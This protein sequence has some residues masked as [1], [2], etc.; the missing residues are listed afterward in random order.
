MMDL[1]QISLRVKIAVIH[2]NLILTVLVVMMMKKLRW[3]RMQKVHIGIFMFITSDIYR[4][5]TDL[6]GLQLFGTRGRSPR[7]SK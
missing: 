2:L 1:S 7:C 6:E 4:L 5:H 3:T